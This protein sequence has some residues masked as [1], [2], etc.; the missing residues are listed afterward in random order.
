M[1]MGRDLTEAINMNMFPDLSEQFTTEKEGDR[2]TV[3]NMSNRQSQTS[4][5]WRNSRRKM[6]AEGH[7]EREE[8]RCVGISGKRHGKRVLG[9]ESAPAKTC[10]VQGVGRGQH[11]TLRSWHVRWV[12]RGVVRRLKRKRVRR[13]EEL[14][15][16]L[17]KLDFSQQ[18]DRKGQVIKPCGTFNYPTPS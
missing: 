15:S 14:A 3:T 1:G 17:R 4:A 11:R 5:R 18:P 16:L 6:R 8:L 13:L 7:L 10:G 9:E 12:D 2:H